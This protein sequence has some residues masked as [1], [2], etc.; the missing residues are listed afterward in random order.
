MRHITVPAILPEVFSS[1]RV[2][3]GIATSALFFIETFGTDKGL[4][5]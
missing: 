5:F 2:A 3:L 4:G 1:L